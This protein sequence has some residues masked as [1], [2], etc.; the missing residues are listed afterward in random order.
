M[1]A[2]ARKLHPSRTSF[3]QGDVQTLPRMGQDSELYFALRCMRTL[4]MLN[5][6]AINMQC[7]GCLSAQQMQANSAAQAHWET[8]LHRVPQTQ[9]SLTIRCQCLS[10]PSPPNPGRYRAAQRYRGHVWC[11]VPML[12]IKPACTA[13]TT[14]SNVEMSAVYSSHKRSLRWAGGGA[15]A[16]KFLV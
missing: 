15:S 11:A 9:K 10:K 2:A 12:S 14:E 5:M 4:A 1:P 16:I 6:D 7:N 8:L 13:V 3:G